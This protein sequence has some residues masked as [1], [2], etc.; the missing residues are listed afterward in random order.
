MFEH[1]K[2]PLSTVEALVRADYHQGSRN[3]K[4]ISYGKGFDIETYRTSRII[5]KP[6]HLLD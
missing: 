6:F 3:P 2:V 5:C 1:H 4:A